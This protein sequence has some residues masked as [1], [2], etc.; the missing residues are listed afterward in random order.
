MKFEIKKITRMLGWVCSITLFSVVVAFAAPE[1]ANTNLSITGYYSGI[2]FESSTSPYCNGENRKYNTDHSLFITPAK[3][4]GVYNSCWLFGTTG[5]LE[6]AIYK[7]FGESLDLSER[8]VM[9]AVSNSTGYLDNPFNAYV[10]KDTAYWGGDYGHEGVAMAYWTRGSVGGLISE[11]LF[12]YYL[13]EPSDK[14]KQLCDIQK[15]SENSLD[16][17]PS[18]IILLGKNDQYSG[19]NYSALTAA[20]YIQD[21]KDLIKAYGSVAAAYYHDDNQYSNNNGDTVYCYNQYG[22]YDYNLWRYVDEYDFDHEV[23]FVGWDD[24]YDFGEDHNKGAFLVKNSFGAYW[25]KP[26]SG[27]GYFWLSYDCFYTD[28]LAVPQVVHKSDLYDRIYETDGT[29]FSDSGYRTGTFDP[30]D[31]GLMK[32]TYKT[33]SDSELLTGIMIYNDVPGNE[34]KVYYSDDDELTSETKWT[35]LSIKSE[36]AVSVNDFSGYI[37]AMNEG[38]LTMRFVDAPAVSGNYSLAVVVRNSN[39]KGYVIH[40]TE[41]S[42]PLCGTEEN[43][44]LWWDTSEINAGN[45]NSARRLDDEDTY[46]INFTLKAYTKQIKTV[47]TYTEIPSIYEKGE[48][49]SG[50]SAIFNLESWFGSIPVYISAT[51]GSAAKYITANVSNGKLTI[52]VDSYLRS[53]LYNYSQRVYLGFKDEQG[54]EIRIPV[55]I[56]KEED[57]SQTLYRDGVLYVN[58]NSGGNINI[59]TATDKNTGKQIYVSSP[60]LFSSFIVDLR[61]IKNTDARINLFTLDSNW[62]PNVSAFRYS[63]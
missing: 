3:N 55:I 50:S 54:N 61:C 46:H 62:I 10:G 52:T 1:D 24:D 7:Q 5:A 6:T 27:N 34:Y 23:L 39:G 35:E 4:Q 47:V 14:K 33:S 29:I 9:Y 11:E 12:P 53:N 8:M 44:S 38:Y 16:Y 43:S 18:Q 25:G 51:E 56:G 13:Y 42:D 20:E 57:V 41:L 15:L 2:S 45:I 49:F 36:G 48:T 60:I 28:V 58:S 63:M 37:Q 30:G 32:R 40:G 21:T 26:I 31:Y 17:Y 22:Y 19:D 59:I